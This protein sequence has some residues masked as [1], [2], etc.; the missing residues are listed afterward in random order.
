MKGYAVLF[1]IVALV[2]L[3]L[4]LPAFSRASQTAT[5]SVSL[6][7]ESSSEPVESENS[8]PAEDDKNTF[9]VL[10]GTTVTTLSYRDFLIRT[11]AFEMP[12]TYHPEAL[13]AQVVA[14]YTYHGRRKHAQEKNPDEALAGAHF[15]APDDTFPQNYT[16]E[17]LRERWGDDYDA[18]YKKLGD[19]VDAVMGKVITYHGEWIDACY[20]AMS[21]GTTEAAKD[22]WGSD[23]PYLQS[24]ASD[25]D[26]SATQYEKKTTLSV[27]QVKTALTGET[28]TVKLPENP[29]AWFGKATRSE[30]GMVLTMTVGD[31][32][33]A[34]T[35]L[36]RIFALR[37]AT[38]SVAYE[39][40]AFC[41]TVKGYGHGV[42]M[43]QHGANV[44]AKQGYSWKEILRHYYTGVTIE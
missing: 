1:L 8:A 7:S 23:V 5:P 44:L 29:S 37:S 19:A 40:D 22:V 12:P 43:S 2:L 4:P 36:R 26:K 41:F 32:S 18:Y 25:G 31:T 10:T 15:K 42:G 38:F 9:K 17:K 21:N 27:E 14:A 39:N 20:C 35:A 6:P 33:F 11:L 28:P 3:L 16:E 34:G 30:T 24:V 13:K